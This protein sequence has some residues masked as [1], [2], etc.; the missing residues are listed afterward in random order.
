MKVQISHRGTE[1]Q[2]SRNPSEALNLPTDKLTEK[3]IGCAIEVHRQL[4]PGLLESIYESAMC[5]ELESAG[6]GF[7]RQV[8]VPI[9]YRGRLIGE[10][11][12]DLIVEKAVVVE[13]KSVERFD[14]VFEAQLLTYLKLTS[15]RIGLLINFNSRLLRDGIRR[16][17]L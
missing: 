8:L 9:Q 3:I 10:H 11:R 15:L 12:L 17:I 6:I 5:I 7:Q 16:F 4:G 13:L 1:A 14:P 2:S